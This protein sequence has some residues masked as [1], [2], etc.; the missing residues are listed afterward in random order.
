MQFDIT[1]A[2]PT[3]EEIQRE[4]TKL[5]DDSASEALKDRIKR[6]RIPATLLILLVN[7]TAFFYLGSDVFLSTLTITIVIYVTLLLFLTYTSLDLIPMPIALTAF[8]SATMPF[9]F[10]NQFDLPPIT[11]QSFIAPT[12]T[13]ILSVFY[14]LQISFYLSRIE[15]INN[16]QKIALE[17][18]NDAPIEDCIKIQ[19]WLD[20]PD[21]LA[22]RNRVNSQGR[23]LLKIEVSSMYEHYN[24]K[25]KQ[26]EIE[27]AYKNVYATD[28]TTSRA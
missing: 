2:P 15:E 28:I 13:L 17:S 4:K 26:A 27:K 18:L 21:I 16:Q 12:L 20:D 24:E 14:D 25:K 3:A 19:D 9:L 7:A 8:T 10:V 1:K 22:Y 6:M 23:H 5:A 11:T